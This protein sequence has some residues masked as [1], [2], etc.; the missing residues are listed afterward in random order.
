MPGQPPANR[1]P[2]QGAGGHSANRQTQG[3]SR[4]GNGSSSYSLNRWL[5]TRERHET[6]DWE[7]KTKQ[8]TDKNNKL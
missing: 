2:R 3:A 6:W 5:S 8:R 7:Q 1:D 4:S